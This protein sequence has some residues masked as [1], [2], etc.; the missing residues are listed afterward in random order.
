MALSLPSHSCHFRHT[1]RYSFHSSTCSYLVCSFTLSPFPS[2][3]LSPHHPLH[4]IYHDAALTFLYFFCRI[5]G[6]SPPALPPICSDSL[7]A[8]LYALLIRFLFLL[9]PSL[10]ASLAPILIGDNKVPTSL[11]TRSQAGANEYATVGSSSPT[12][13]DDFDDSS[14]SDVGA[15]ELG[16]L[17]SA[18]PNNTH[19]IGNGT[20]RAYRGRIPALHG[21]PTAA[22]VSASGETGL[23][24]PSALEAGASGS[25]W[26]P[27]TPLFTPSQLQRIL[28]ALPA[29]YAAS[30]LRLLYSL[31]IHGAELSTFYQKVA[32]WSPVLLL[33]KDESGY[34]FGAFTSEPWR[35]R[36]NYFGGPRSVIFSISPRFH[37]YRITNKNNFISLATRSYIA[38]GG[39][40]NHALWLDSALRNGTSGP[41]Q[42][43][44]SPQLS[45]KPSFTVMGLQAWGFVPP[46]S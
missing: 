5:R 29:V 31:D 28:G 34:L 10:A 8:T 22:L 26:A 4:L 42:T 19:P 43:F 41:C 45:A 13:H 14:D 12:A 30:D 32:D 35:P 36:S 3:L 38:V 9:P 25:I 18:S 6:E 17:R 20:G 46:M 27:G 7:S 37:V 21:V 11:S 15:I 16:A 44:G 2:S 24:N 1:L 33:I 40:D 39:G 23:V